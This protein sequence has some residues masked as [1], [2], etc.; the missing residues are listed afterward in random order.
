MEWPDSSNEMLKQLAVLGISGVAGTCYRAIMNPE[1]P[2]RR[3]L[4]RGA[5]GLLSAVF[6]GGAL[7]IVID[8]ITGAGLWAASAAGFL[9]GSMGEE[10][11]KVIQDRWLGKKDAAE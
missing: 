5:G 7:G 9:M 6:L 11:V 4:V 8:S 1:G 2:W 3:R 10:G